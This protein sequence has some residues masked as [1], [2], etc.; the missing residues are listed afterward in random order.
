[1]NQKY[2]LL[3]P[4]TAPNGDNGPGVGNEYD[5]STACR[6]CGTGAVPKGDLKTCGIRK[7][8]KNV[9]RTHDWKIIVDLP[10]AETLKSYGILS[11]P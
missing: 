7:T 1:M 9:F 2:Y 4:T 10:F 11:L 5:M 3:I 6:T 8:K